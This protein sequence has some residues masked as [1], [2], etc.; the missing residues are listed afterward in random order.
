[1]RTKPTYLFA[2]A[3]V[4]AAF[5][6]TNTQAQEQEYVA[7]KVVISKERVRSSGKIYYAH[8]VQERQTLYSISKA[9]IVSVEEIYK[10]NPFM[11]L[12]TEGLKKGQILLIPYDEERAKE[13]AAREQGEKDESAKEAAAIAE[14]AA[15]EKA[16]QEMAAQEKAAQEKAAKEEAAREKAAKEEAARVKA[17]QEK[18][19]KEEAAREKAAQKEAARE[20]AEQ[21]RAAKEEAARLKAEQDK[22]AKEEAERLKAEQDEAARAKAEKERAAKEAAAKA[23]AEQESSSDYFIHKVKWFEDLDAIAKKYGVSKES[24]KNINRMTSDKLKRRQDLKIPRDPAAWEGKTVVVAENNEPDDKTENNPILYQPA[25]TKEAQEGDEGNILDDLFVREGKHDVNISM[26]IPFSSPKSGDR[27]S[28][29]DFYCGA[30][31][32]ARTIGK[33]GTNLDIHTYDVGGG[34][35][36]VTHDRLSSSDFTIGPVT[37]TDIMKASAISEGDAWIVSPLDMQVEPLTDTLAGLIQAPTPTSIQIKDMVAWIKSDLRHEDRVLVVTPSSPQS[38]YLNL[39]EKEMIEAGLHHSTT[40]LSSMRPLMTSQGTNRIVLACDYTDRSTVFLIEALRNLYMVSSRNTPVVL[41]STSK[42]RTY[43]QIEVE[44]L[45]KVNLHACVTYFVDYDSKDVRDFL[46]QY[47]ALYNAEPSR[48]AYSGYDLMMYFS[49]LA[50][51]YGRR[52]PRAL[53]KVE[54]QGL[55]SDFNLVRT[56]SG[57]YVNNA[58]RRVVYNPDYSI[59]LVR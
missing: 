5:C 3:L 55:Q 1:M 41:Y 44:Q 18:A 26:L 33:E 56:D 30:L 45:H 23:K 31:L 15:R 39:V 10:A 54:F 35:L 2:V 53:R 6:S 28:F 25:D 52:W 17:A 7:P 49:T 19:A 13:I 57:S 59:T 51:K 21:D 24:I 22:A 42:I 8:V 58:V 43:D 32:A 50:H 46:L 36:P 34:N 29:M 37:K 27:V 47:R 40:T 38:D 20:K 4:L 11:N 9:Y 16:A 14:Q 12:E 48:S